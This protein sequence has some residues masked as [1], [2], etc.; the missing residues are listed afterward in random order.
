MSRITTQFVTLLCF[1]SSFGFVGESLNWLADKG[2]ALFDNALRRHV[3]DGLVNY[4]AIAKDKDFQAFLSWLDEVDVSS[5]KSRNDEMAFWINAYNALAIKGVVDN[6]PLE[7]VID[8]A[9]FFNEQK[10]PVAG[11]N[12]TLDQLEKGTIFKRFSEPRLHFVLVCAAISCPNLPAEAYTGETL[13]QR[14]DEVTRSFLNNL[15]QNRLD[16]KTKT[17][18]LSR[19]FDWYR[20]DFVQDDTDLLD[21]VTPY[22]D[23]E[24]QAFLSENDVTIA[25]LDY[26][27]T[28]NIRKE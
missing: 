28:L 17:F 22:L 4:E 8:V 9:G 24:K 5:F 7:K 11:R 25:Y 14:I 26:D 18:Y 27:W 3:K 23:E 19:I 6:Y 13:A 20:R 10:H 12:L 2:H 21:F 16:K 1:L 15:D